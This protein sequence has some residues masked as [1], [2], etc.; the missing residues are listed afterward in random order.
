MGYHL[1]PIGQRGDDV[2]LAI[3]DINNVEFEF[4]D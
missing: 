2:Y 3:D 4:E 1:I